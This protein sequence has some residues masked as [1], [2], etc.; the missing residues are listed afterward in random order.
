MQGENPY[1]V[2]GSRDDAAF[3]LDEARRWLKPLPEKDLRQELAALDVKTAKRGETQKELRLRLEIFTAELRKYPGDVVRD[4]LR[5]WR[6]VFFP[7]WAELRDAI[8]GDR[9]ALERRQRIAALE[10][11][12]NPAP[13][14][15]IGEPPTEEQIARNA[16]WASE[17]RGGGDTGLSEEKRARLA[18]VDRLHG[19]SAKPKLGSWKKVQEPGLPPSPQ[20][21][22]IGTPPGRG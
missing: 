1:R 18:E 4:A 3:A 13:A 17:L 8:E 14:E 19:D 6:G 10:A 12:L 2:S 11:F 5:G 21:S 22:G 7:A 9:R 16:Q 15:P 20:A